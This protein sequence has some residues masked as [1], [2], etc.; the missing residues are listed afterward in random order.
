MTDQ[1]EQR[2][3]AAI[4]GLCAG[5]AISWPAWWH[6]LAQLPPRRA[7]RLAEA[8][9]HSQQWHT[10]S[11][12]TPYLHATSPDVIDPAGP[13]DDAEWFVISVRHHL[14]QGLDGQPVADGE[15]V[16]E[17]LAGQRAADPVRVRGRI[18]TAM[19]LEALAHGQRPPTSGNDN[20]HWFD[21]VA[22]VRAVAAG[23]LRPGAPEVA[24]DLAADDAAYT[25]ALDGLWGARATAALVAAL[26]AG[27]DTSAAVRSALAQLPEGSWI[28]AVAEESL[29]AVDGGSGGLQLAGRLERRVVDHVYAFANQAP[30]TV[31]LLLAHL[32]V[33]DGRDALLL[34]ALGHPRHADA[35]VPLAGAI[36]GAAFGGPVDHDDLP[37]LR[38]VAIPAMAGVA[39]ADVAADVVDAAR[40]ATGPASREASS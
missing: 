26:V 17:Q 28:R 15:G 2:T 23:L 25:H 32:S 29:A 18:G 11:V 36:A 34:G 3:R 39:M 24:A 37:V 22:C 31:G 14:Q 6:R 16:W 33:A 12:P 8:Q 19:A 40:A 20:V 13:T 21:D 35:L 27:R 5:D 4:A 10:T 1:I 38:G 7:V 30:E 9:A